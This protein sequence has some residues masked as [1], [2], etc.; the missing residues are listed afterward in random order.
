MKDLP[1]STPHRSSRLG[2]CHRRARTRCIGLE[3]SQQTRVFS[4]QVRHAPDD[5]RPRRG[6]LMEGCCPVRQTHELEEELLK[7]G[8]TAMLDAY[9]RY[10]HYE[11]QL[12]PLGLRA[13][14]YTNPVLRA[15]ATRRQGFSENITCS[16]LIVA[17][18]AEGRAVRIAVLPRPPVGPPLEHTAAAV[19]VSAADCGHGQQARGPPAAPA[20]RQGRVRV[21][22][23]G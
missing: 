15:H 16:L 8:A 14:R 3:G 5:R 21:R 22:S 12:D 10:G 19:I 17:M 4:V 2:Q 7:R 23:S 1:L 6:N 11:A 18:Q 13:P 9:Q 20:L